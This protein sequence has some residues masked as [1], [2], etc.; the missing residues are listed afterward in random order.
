MKIKSKDKRM[1]LYNYDKEFIGIDEVDLSILG[2]ANL[3]ELKDEALDFADMFVKTPGHVHNF[4]HIHWID[5]VT[6]ADSI[7]STK[8]IIHAKGKNF[9]CLLDI[10]TLYLSDKPSSKAFLVYLNNIREVMDNSD[11]T[12]VLFSPPITTP[13]FIAPAIE[14][15]P[16]QEIGAPLELNFEDECNIDLEQRNDSPTQE[17]QIPSEIFDNGYIFDPHVASE[18]LGLPVDL[19]EE[20]IED[21]I[22]QA[23]EFKD[24]LYASLDSNDRDTIKTLSHKLKGVAANLRIEDAL[25]SLTIIHNSQNLSEIKTQVDLFYQIIMKLAGEKVL[26][27]KEIT[28]ESS[29]QSRESTEVNELEEFSFENKIDREENLD[30]FKQEESKPTKEIKVPKYDTK[31]VASE[32]GLSQENITELFEDYVSEAKELSRSISQAIQDNDQKTWAKKAIQLKVI[33]DS[34]RV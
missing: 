22:A 20:F 26:I 9:R 34:M 28:T 16:L 12:E 18:E 31:T 30:I 21:F 13:S 8:V 2:F 4:K 11:A 5:F 17:V 10:K 15:E 14:E 33:S 7:Q 32:I 1:L 23:K 29:T 6:C 25:E 24:A 19:I 27:S 3:E